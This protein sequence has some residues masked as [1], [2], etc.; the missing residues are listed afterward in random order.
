[1][2]NDP[3]KTAEGLFEL[4]DGDL[5]QGYLLGSKCAHCGTVSFPKRKIC[6]GCL[7]DDRIEEIPLSKRGKLFSFSINQMAP[8]GFKAP[9]VT[10]KVDLPEKVRIFAVI[11]GCP[12]EEDALSIGMDMEMAFEPV[13]RGTN[14]EALVG[15]T[16]RPAGTDRK[17]GE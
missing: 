13:Y 2:G 10:G 14:G 6:P 12:P 8:E 15:Y 9:Y 1:M 17:N 5:D 7:A 4:P 16:F 3:K 11:T